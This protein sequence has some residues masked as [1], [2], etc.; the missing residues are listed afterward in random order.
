M[1]GGDTI[2][3]DNLP[4][5]PSESAGHQDT[6][7]PDQGR[8]A[9]TP[10]ETA[11]LEAETIE[12]SFFPELFHAT[13][14]IEEPEAHLHPQLQHGLVRYLRRVTLDRPE[15]QVII[16]THSAEMASACHPEDLV[17]LRI[18]RHGQRVAR[19]V[20]NLPY[21]KKERRRI[22]RRA[23]L[24]LDTARSASLFAERLV[25]VEGVTDALILRRLGE[26][27][28][29]DE[30][31]Q[32]EF[33]DA[34]TII[35]IGSR[36]G[37]W[38]VQLLATPDYELISRLALLRDTDSRDNDLSDP[39]SW[40]ARFD[41]DVVQC[42]LSHPTIEPAITE[43][44]EDN[45]RR[46]LSAAGIDPPADITPEAIDKIFY[47][48][49]GRHRKG[50]FAF[51]FAH[52]V[53]RAIQKGAIPHVPEFMSKLFCFLIADSPSSLEDPGRDASTID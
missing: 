19:P 7:T 33:I 45:V 52:E 16:S 24:H 36:I 26:A 42:F 28:S 49:R 9:R 34:L 15:L 11:D 20:A 27:W 13:I 53:E 18:D 38:I 35:P 51:A 6:N 2:P 37:E 39:P 48:G 30:P 31:Y 23:R 14:V 22:L 17:V 50:D 10:L 3:N 46:A 40:L 25:V 47:S 44:N 21:R 8:D 32:R 43:Y 4:A 1:P 29:A 5:N 41:S 12:D